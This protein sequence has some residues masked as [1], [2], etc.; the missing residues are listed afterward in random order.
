MA[1]GMV[2]YEPWL[3]EDAPDQPGLPYP[4]W[5]G[6]DIDARTVLVHRPSRLED[7]ILLANYFQDLISRAGQVIID[8]SPGLRPLLRR[9]FPQTMENSGDQKIDYLLTPAALPTHFKRQTEIF[10]D[11]PG[12]LKVD[13]E[14]LAFWQRCL[15]SLGPGSKIGVCITR[16]NLVENQTLE[17]WISFFKTRGPWQ[18]ININPELEKQDIDPLMRNTST[19]LHN[20]GF[21]HLQDLDER[22]ALIKTCDAV[23]S[24]SEINLALAAAT[25]TQAWPARTH[26]WQDCEEVAPIWHPVWHPDAG[27][28]TS[29]PKC[30]ARYN[31][32]WNL[33]QRAN[34]LDWLTLEN[35][36]EIKNDLPLHKDRTDFNLAMISAQN[37]YWQSAQKAMTRAYAQDKN[38]TDGFSQ[39]GWVKYEATDYRG[40]LPLML[41]DYKQGRMTPEWQLKLA[42]ALGQVGDFKSAE[43]VVEQAYQED[44]RLKDGFAKVGMLR[45]NYP[46]KDY[47]FAKQLILKD[48]ETDRI[49]TAWHYKLV[50]VNSILGEVDAAL[51]ILKDLYAEDSRFVDG[52]ARLGWIGFLQ[53]G[54]VKFF[55]EMLDMDEKL[56]RSSGQVILQSY[57]KAAIGSFHVAEEM[58][59]SFLK[60]NPN[61]K[62]LRTILG[63]LYM[64]YGKTQKGYELLH[65][66][67]SAKC[68]S[69]IWYP[70]YTLALNMQKNNRD[71][72]NVLNI[73]SQYKNDNDLIQIGS[74]LVPEMVISCSKFKTIIEQGYGYDYLMCCK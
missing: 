16:Q 55:K 74:H 18:F 17:H 59:M 56:K 58:I 52:H 36:P 23:I 14:K 62:D 22:A 49:T 45:M 53:K 48:F 20:P 42:E 6:Q 25:G 73:F 72:L 64:K 60:Q 66:D 69:L 41:K 71:A 67:F 21:D 70:I 35:D 37:N 61:S 51:N 5:Q 26:G 46:V 38:L 47:Q 10:I 43:A 12:Y 27:A 68:M 2:L 31:T 34:I 63:W 50:I 8:P 33:P 19:A 9:S 57:Y 39:L 44:R 11:G 15:T 24:E 65:Q 13:P 28:N 3:P 40:A 29:P 4:V 30:L 54:D 32:P 1:E 7:E